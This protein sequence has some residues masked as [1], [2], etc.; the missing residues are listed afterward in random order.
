MVPEGF[1]EI[2]EM[3]I[4]WNPG[5]SCNRIDPDQVPDNP[6][7]SVKVLDKLDATVAASG[8]N[9]PPALLSTH[10]SNPERIVALLEA[11]PQA[12]KVYQKSGAANQPVLV[13]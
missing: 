3:K 2:D 4:K 9:L 5:C 10:P 6:E 1:I 12:P 8:K 11:M 13:R 7:E